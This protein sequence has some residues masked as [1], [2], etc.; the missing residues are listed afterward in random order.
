MKIQVVSDLHIEELKTRAKTERGLEKYFKEMVSC[1]GNIL[2]LNG[3]IGSVLDEK[4]WL[5][6]KYIDNK[7]EKIILLSG[8]HEYQ[9]CN[10][11]KEEVDK[12]ISERVI[13]EYKNVVFLQRGIIEIGEYVIMG[14]TLWSNINCSS[15]KFNN[16]AE[17]PDFHTIKDFRG[18]NISECIKIYNKW[19]EKDRLW[20]EE[21]IGRFYNGANSKKVLV[22]ATHHAPSF[23]QPCN[24]RYRN[25][26]STLTYCSDLSYMFR[27][28]N[29][30][31]YGHTHFDCTYEHK[32]KVKG[33]DN[34]I[35]V[36][37]QRG[38]PQRIN[39]KYN[40]S[41]SL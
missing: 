21:E 12:Y 8:N 36:S 31:I 37:N 32:Y 29:I 27:F 7:Y 30:W 13:N 3:D 34:F 18:K 33:I 35:L 6:L 24:P 2:I 19:Y 11:T 40:S 1:A 17:W 5:F 41:F 23:E 20:L 4:Y 10:M 14:C 28:I 9:N 25:A 16:F 22:V 39:N 26:I 38:S 15:D